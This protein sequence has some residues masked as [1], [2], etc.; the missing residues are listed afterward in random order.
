MAENENKQ[1]TEQTESKGSAALGFALYKDANFDW[2]RFR[3]YLKEDWGIEFQEEPKDGATV[4][5]VGDQMAACS[6]MPMPVPEHEA[7]ECAKNNVLWE[8]AEQE[9]A[10][11]SAHLLLA[12]MDHGQPLEQALLLCKLASSA[13]KLKNAIGFYHNP[14]VYEKDF[15][16][17]N[18]KVMKDDELPMPILIYTHMYL[19]QAAQ[20]SVL[21]GFTYGLRR[22]GKEEIEILETSAQPQELF[23]F[24]M[25]IAEY[26]L[27]SDEELKDGDTIGF[28]ED[29]KLPIK[30]SDA[31]NFTGQSLKIGFMN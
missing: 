6:L 25:S 30:L 28:T 5:R 3:H 20:G 17:Q 15:Y 18:A 23:G 8:H 19:S 27:T 4:F 21:N 1:E 14:T 26:T 13:M 9:V 10:K 22:F 24:L 12:V 16:V 7:E 31:V 29:E 2:P 11:H